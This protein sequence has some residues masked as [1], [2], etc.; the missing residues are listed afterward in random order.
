MTGYH[1][2]NI[3]IP[4]HSSTRD[5]Q[6][7]ESGNHIGWPKIQVHRRMSI[8]Q[9]KNRNNIWWARIAYGYWKE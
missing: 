5:T 2:D 7:V 6:E 8:L 3:G 9:D 4:T 1:Q